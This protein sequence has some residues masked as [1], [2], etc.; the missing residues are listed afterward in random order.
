MRLVDMW[1]VGSRPGALALLFA[2]GV[3]CAFLA[4]AAMAQDSQVVLLFVCALAV[5]GV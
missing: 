2:A 1:A 3:A 5:L 4:G